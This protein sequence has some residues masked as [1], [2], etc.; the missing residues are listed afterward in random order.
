MLVANIIV[1]VAVTVATTARSQ[2]N[3]DD[4]T[5]DL[6]ITDSSLQAI[7]ADLV[8]GADADPRVPFDYVPPVVNFDG[9][10]PFTTVGTL[11]P[12]KISTLK[13]VDYLTNGIT[14]GVFGANPIG[15]VLDFNAVDS[16]VYKIAGVG[17]LP[18]ENA[19]ESGVSPDGAQKISYE[20][21]SEAIGFSALSSGS[22]TLNVQAWEES[23]RLDIFVKNADGFDNGN[24]DK[25]VLL[26]HD[27]LNNHSKHNHDT[28]GGQFK[29]HDHHNDKKQAPHTHHIGAD[30]HTDADAAVPA[31]DHHNDPAKL[32]RH[33]HN[34]NDT[35]G[36]H[37]DDDHE[38]GVSAASHQHI[39]DNHLHVHDGVHPHGHNHV[40]HNHEADDFHNG[41]ATVTLELDGEDLAYLME[42]RDSGAPV[43]LTLKIVATVVAD[44]LHHHHVHGNGDDGDTDGNNNWVHDHH[45]HWH[46]I[47]RPDFELWTDLVKFTMTGDAEVER[48]LATTQ[49]TFKHGRAVDDTLI[50][51]ALSDTINNLALDDT[52]YYTM[53]SKGG[54]PDFEITSDPFGLSRLD[55]ITVP[56]VLRTDSVKDVTVKVS[57]Y[58]PTDPDHGSDGYGPSPDLTQVI[59][60][61]DID[62]SMALQVSREDV[63]FVNGST[64]RVI[65]LKIKTETRGQLQVKLDKLVFLGTTTDVSTVSP[66][67][68]T[69]QYISPGVAELG[70]SLAGD[71][72]LTAL[73]PNTSY[74]LRIYNVHPGL[75]NVNWAFG[76]LTDSTHN[77]DDG[78][79]ELAIRV[80][81]GLV[82][83]ANNN[84]IPPGR[85][86]ENPEGLKNDLV[87][88]AH[89]HPHHGETYLRTGFIEVDEGMYTI[90]F[91]N[92]GDNDEVG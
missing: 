2:A 34:H 49:P 8:R 15:T 92:E 77:P 74:V 79:D 52:L 47:N 42:L 20:M 73:P 40:S 16:Q 90:V 56:I 63:A 50:N 19:T 17:V 54:N 53:D 45:H 37:H 18:D 62:R 10:V 88:R 80:Y 55:E 76:A 71:P 82:T 41:E 31:H 5:Q 86:G 21:T 51:Q 22:V 25:S 28:G 26:D 60:G 69:H 70:S 13:S 29:D 6:Y 75:L 38:V 33:G 91:S 83:D 11:D 68:A 87:G 43:V 81:R 78:D 67:A 27:H 12:P 1:P 30:H 32:H 85:A 3:L 61:K 64:P 44:P 23:A 4:I 84:L 39:G 72:D 14:A 7:I 65:K 57:V 58:N 24:P 9:V 35:D 48:V 59:N 36:D 46:H 66:R 89:I